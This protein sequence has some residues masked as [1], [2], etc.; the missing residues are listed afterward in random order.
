MPDSVNQTP[1]EDTQSKVNNGF[2]ADVETLGQN[3]WAEGPMPEFSQVMGGFNL[4]SYKFPDGSQGLA[5]YNGKVAL[6]FDNNNNITMS[7]GPPGQSG[8]GGK[9]ITNVQQQLTKAKSVVVEVT[10]RDDG[11]VV[12]KEKGE[13][14]NIE[15]DSLP[16]YSLKVY[17]P[18]MIEALGGDVA[19]KGDN[20]TLNA[21]STLNLRSNKDINI[22]AGENGGKINML[23]SSVNLDAAFFNKNISGSDTTT[24]A[25]EVRVE[26]NKAGAEVTYNTPGSVRYIVN[27]NYTVGVKGNYTT[28]VS[29]KYILNVDGDY[30]AKILGDYANVVSGKGFAKFNGVNSKSQQIPNYYI[31]VLANK[32]AKLP[33]MEINSSSALNFVNSV[34]GFKFDTGKGLGTM[35]LTEKSLFKV[36][37][38]PRLGAINLDKKSA[39]MEYGKTA[40]ISMTAEE[41]KVE[42]FKSFLSLKPT[43]SKLTSNENSFISVKPSDVSVVAP[44][45]YLN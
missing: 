33:G 18:V 40:K 25:G 24:G 12:N 22:Q 4:T 29:K 41:S 15:E 39:S 44:M 32:K 2:T 14:G 13:N 28:D 16:S 11:G 42:N 7:A 6:H 37:T 17:G 3:Y 26:Q 9:M 34:G 10:G 8:C 38:G 21:G 31:D 5:I 27:G 23:G 19:I 45:I 35:E 20:V 43:E 36:T 1:S 30:G